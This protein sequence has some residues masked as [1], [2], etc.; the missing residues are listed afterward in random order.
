MRAPE[1]APGPGHDHHSPIADAHRPLF[2][3]GTAGYG[4]RVKYGITMFATDQSMSVPA[5]ARA[6]EDRGLHSLYL[7]EHTHIPTSR[8]TPAPTGDAELAEEYRRTVD[9]LVAL[10]AAATITEKIRLGTGICLVAQREPI[11]T[12]NAVATLDQLSNGRFEFGI[13]FGWNHEEMENHGVDVRRR[14]ERCREHVLTM[15]AIW[16]NE[17]ASFDG[18]FVHLE[19]SWSWPKPA[20]PGGPPILI[21]GMAGPKLFAAIA[22]YG[23]GWIPIGGAGVRAALPDL[24]RACEATGRDPDALR[25]VP[26]GTLPDAGKLEYYESI[27]INEVVLRVP[28]GD[29]NKVLPILDSYAPL[30]AEKG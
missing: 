28:T 6:A 5:L 4:T 29:E 14:R 15:K 9:P 27:G 13:G 24:H 19:P 16:T 3:A 1:A 7:P 21:G 10:A 23:D 2:L 25:I 12:A 18:E 8:R 11:V 30:A 26:F 22:E 17:V 20:Q